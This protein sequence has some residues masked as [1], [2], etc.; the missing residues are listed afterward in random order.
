[1][2]GGVSTDPCYATVLLDEGLWRSLSAVD[3]PH[4]VTWVYGCA[5]DH[6]HRGDH[7]ALV[8]HIGGQS[9]W[10]Q[11]DE[12][13]RP[14]INT[15]D[16]SRPPG[17]E[18]GPRGEPPDHPGRTTPPAPTA[19]PLAAMPA[20]RSG[21]PTPASQAEALWAIAAALERLAE[22]IAAALDFGGDTGRHASGYGGQSR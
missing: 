5:L 7:Q 13:G 21:S 18:P 3:G 15:T 12:S 22:V 14:R 4:E 2:G 20:K 6:G 8:Y 9:Y 16:Q 1:M 19:D 17:P 11:W 10:A